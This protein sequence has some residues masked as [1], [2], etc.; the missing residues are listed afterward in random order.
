MVNIRMKCKEATIAMSQPS[1]KAGVAISRRLMVFFSMLFFSVCLV[2]FAYAAEKKVWNSYQTPLF[3]GSFNYGYK[4]YL[5]SGTHS[6]T[7]HLYLSYN[8]FLSKNKAGWVGGG[9]EIPISYV[10]TN[11]DGTFSLFLNGAKLD[12]VYL[13][14][15]SRYHTKIETYLKI[16]KKTGAT[17]EKGEYWLVTDTNGTEYRFGNNLDSE[18]MVN[19]LLVTPYVWRWSLDRIMDRNGNCVY[20]TYAEN[21]TANDKGAVYLSKI[22]Y[23]TEKKR[24][25][26]FILEESDR[27]DMSLIIDQGSEVQEAR[28]LSE[29]RVS[30]NGQL[31]KKLRLEYILNAALDTSLLSSITK[32]GSDGTT[33]LPPERFEYTPFDDG[34]KTD[35]LTKITGALG[36]I[37]TVNYS[38][39]SSFPNTSF[40]ENYWAVTSITGDNGMTGPHALSSA[41]TLAYE[42]GLFDAVSQEFRGYGKVTET[43][44][45]GSK[46]V[47][48][49]HQDDA[50][51]GREESSTLMDAQNAPYLA[52]VNLWTSSL[53]DGIQTVRLEKTEEYTYDGVLANPK[54]TKTEYKNFDSYGNAGLEVDYGDIAVTGDETYTYRE[55]VYNPD[56]WIVN[57][58]KH[59]YI[60]AV[61]NGTKLRES[62]FYYDRAF[63]IDQSP[64]EGNL[65]QEQHWNNNGA[66]PVI[67]YKYD[68]FGN[69]ERK[70]D[71]LG[72]STE[73]V[74][75]A[76]YHTFPEFVYNAKNHLVTTHFN[77][78][79]GK[80]LTEIDPNGNTTTYVYDV[81]NR[82]TKIIK[83]YDSE[84]FPTTEMQYV[85][86][87]SPPHAV[88]VKNR[89][90]AEGTTFDSIQIIDGMGKVIQ[91]KS[92]YDNP[93]NMVASD[94]YYDVM[95]RGARQSNPYLTD[96]A[97]AY[98]SPNTGIPATQ[99]GY[100]I[101]GRP[102]LITN[103]DNTFSTNVY[104]HWRVTGTDENGHTKSQA[105]DSNNKLIQVLEN[106]QGE[107]YTT[108]YHYSPLGEMLTITDHLGNTST[109]EYDSLGRKSRLVDVD[110]GQRL[111]SYDL[112]GNM[113]SQTDARGTMIKYQY[114][115]LNRQTL[116]DYPNDKDIQFVYDLNTKGALS[117][118]YNSLGI[119]SY[120]YDQR[121]RKI[122]EDRT[123]DT[124]SWT[125]KWEYDSMDRVVRQTYPDGEI[126]QYSYNA[127]DKLAAIQRAAQTIMNNITYNAAGEM[128][129]KSYG[130]GWNTAFTYDPSN[131]R[132]TNIS[133][134]K[135]QDKLQ[136][137]IYTYDNAGN[138]KT[139]RDVVAARTETFTYD[140]LHRMLNAH[141]DLV[142]GGFDN[143]YV[144]N[145]I[146]NLTSETDNKTYNV[147]QYTYGQG[148]AKPHA[149]TGKAQK[150]PIIGSFVIDGGKAYCTNQQV[151]LNNISM[152]SP[153]EY[154]AS[155]NADF[156]GA[157]WQTY[158]TAPVFTMSAVYGTKK[159]YFK[160]RNANGESNIKSDDIEFLLDTD[161]D[162]IPDIYDA[163][164][165]NDGIPDSWE[166][167]NGM[168][169][170]DPSDAS[171]NSDSDN[172]TNYQ[173]YLYGTNRLSGDTDGD[174]WDDYE[175]VFN[176]GSNPSKADTDSDG[177]ND[178]VDP[179]PKN[180][181]NDGVSENYVTK[182]WIFN[183]GGNFRSSETFAIGDTLGSGFSKSPLIDT[184]GDGIPDSWETQYG[185]NPANPSD[186][187]N[188]MDGDGLINLQEYQKGTRP[189]IA[190]TDSDGWSDYQE[191]YIYHTDPNNADTDGD[192]I[193]DSYD[194]V[195]LQNANHYSVSENF[196]IRHGNFNEGGSASR[197]S[198]SYMVLNDRI[199][200]DFTGHVISTLYSTSL[201]IAPETVD[202]QNTTIGETYTVSVS[203]LNQG[204]ENMV[205][206]T[207][208]IGGIDIEEFST[209]ND[210][211]SNRII[212]PSVSCMV[213][214]VFK[215]KS[216]GAKG[217]TL[218]VP[219]NDAELKNANVALL[220]IA[221]PD[222]TLPETSII[223]KPSNPSNSQT[224]EFTFIS[225]EPGSTF[226]C[227]I[228]G[229]S[230]LPCESPK[231]YTGFTEGG[232]TFNV[233]ATDAASNTDFSPATYTWTVDTI[234]PASSITSPV[235]GGSVSGPTLT[236]KGTASD[237]DS[238]VQKVEISTDG[239]STWNIAA[240]TTSWSYE[241]TITADG[242]YTIKSRAT[243]NA[244]NVEVSGSGITVTAYTS[245]AI[246]VSGSGYNY[247]QPGFRASLSMSVNGS[248]LETSWLTYYYT[249]LR[250]NLVSTSITGISVS[251]NTVTI[252]GTGTVNGITGYTFIITIVD[253]NP[254][255]IEIVIY[256]PDGTIYF[257]SGT[258]VLSSGDFS[259]EANICTSP[260]RIL[261][262]TPL[263]YSTLQEAYD[264]ASDG[265]I[266]QSQAAGFTEDIIIDR[267]ITVTLE[268]GYN[269]DYSVR[270]GKTTLNGMITI[271]D[272]VIT[273]EDFELQ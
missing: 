22:E 189:D 159:I 119:D 227:R 66:N 108:G 13:T 223:N 236:I 144:Y 76:D 56:L 59:S 86:N 169:P 116:I 15:D 136:D 232:H 151:V 241:W 49:F 260:V 137:F 173:E 268:G 31:A 69:L 179:N 188:D 155:E 83:P 17:N 5:P 29:I 149:V 146:G 235:N 177:L 204:I 200:N 42:N 198:E 100:D 53:S 269:C 34:T 44:P 180:P 27:P 36:D 207:M 145:A 264:A 123:M 243:D 203:L 21:P 30:V 1:E 166:L 242:T 259:V 135:A 225:S 65:T 244:G 98:S 85:I 240:G 199:G 18:N 182:G 72:H 181:Y 39:S 131:L 54:I 60:T 271:N 152:G 38:T 122:Q 254:D 206:G 101:L 82:L 245:Y 247:P 52:A 224:A 28:R 184:D 84:T 127:Q 106:N 6:M 160:I 139:L 26:E 176:R 110:L 130:N 218:N 10:Q 37:T 132:L 158:S 220:A 74:Y 46:A 81:F 33:A 230:Y 229:G 71:P 197:S 215:P 190:D 115:A 43:R 221:L 217:A 157:T 24:V 216:A 164:D 109:H 258:D 105:F 273:I 92:E 107:A 234:K 153:S 67:S 186:A 126:V 233:S 68:T 272:G 25:V 78:A 102:T 129:Q 187:L 150:L 147:T 61:E 40:P 256:N 167:A 50:K 231:S 4:I 104:D 238:V 237:T 219:Y 8:S 89:E 99:T 48:I 196:S 211:C 262:L 143:S 252:T 121:G 267:N 171:L 20:F 3:S 257:Q 246:A 178:P 64:F 222:I 23:N 192:G 57:K 134:T 32:Y 210:N 113:T 118:V 95:G 2:S 249:K 255:T 239:G 88:I 12:L 201:L 191:I 51:K 133:T 251:G 73:I 63:S 154:M 79:T 140:D 70:T 90:T 7:P 111:F 103:P 9:W 194:P 114:D 209:M 91:T 202:F 75:D 55:F 263:Y 195:P 124:N 11:I 148:T 253:G 250:L 205:F 185:M 138:V 213:E 175:E 161:N 14:A 125:T 117:M 208:S 170:L 80:P 93:A 141:D 261:D 174:G 228:D 58:V 162:G 156:F 16:E 94:T 226:E 45:D 19:N 183:E 97:M 47:H 120:K 168:N 112:A 165:D 128:T 193:K 96:N 172:L 265:D 163:D 62:W 142:T 266:I 77:P 35:L 212:S 214:A 270:T 248:S 87:A 41:S